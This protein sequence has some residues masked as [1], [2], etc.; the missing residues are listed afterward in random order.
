M[1]MKAEKPDKGEK[2]EQE[3]GELT[4]EEMDQVSGGLNLLQEPVIR[5]LEG[6][7]GR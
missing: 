7:Q 3:K 1:N 2:Q 4:L 5:E 6:S